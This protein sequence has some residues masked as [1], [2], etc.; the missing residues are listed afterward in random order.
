MRKSISQKLQTGET[1][2][3]QGPHSSLSQAILP[4]QLLLRG[5]NLSR[6]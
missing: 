2:F 4:D 1:A 6:H 3:R 5:S